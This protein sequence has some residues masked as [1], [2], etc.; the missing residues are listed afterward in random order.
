MTVEGFG[1][2]VGVAWFSW[3]FGVPDVSELVR[4]SLN[5]LH[6]SALLVFVFW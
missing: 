6:K 1:R 2:G 3:G 4:L 5:L